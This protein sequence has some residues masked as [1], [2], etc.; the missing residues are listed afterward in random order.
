MIKN[1][2]T[3]CCVYKVTSLRRKP[4][5][6]AFNSKVAHYLCAHIFSVSPL[7]HSAV[8]FSTTLEK[9]LV[10]QQKVIKD[11]RQNLETM[12]YNQYIMHFPIT[13]DDLKQKN[14]SICK[15]PIYDL[16]NWVPTN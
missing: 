14:M 11:Y 15:A 12:V 1:T 5:R 16:S 2:V 13:A 9:Q 6:S 10:I 3:F 8:S 4:F 7:Y